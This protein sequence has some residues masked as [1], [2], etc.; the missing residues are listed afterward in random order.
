M[1]NYQIKQFEDKGL[2]HFSYAVLADNQIV[3]IDPARD[4]QP[5]YDFAAAHDA[6]IIG[7]IETHPHADFVS[8]HDEI[9][10]TTGATLYVSEMVGADYRFQAFDEGDEIA[11]GEGIKLKAIHTPGHSPDSI[12][13]VLS[14]NGKNRAVF[15]GDTLFIGDVG[16][17]DLREKAGKLQAK[18]EE[19]A[20][21][22][23]HSTREKLMRLEDDVLVYPAHGSGSLCGKALSDA[24]SSTIGQEKMSNYALQQMTEEEFVK[25]LLEDQ[26]FIPKYFPYNVALNK[27][28]APSYIEGIQ[29]VE[30]LNKNFTPEAGALII[31]GR[32]SGA[33]RSSHLPGAI[34]LMNGEKFETWLGS[35]VSPNESFY[36]V[37]QDQDALELLIEKSAKIGYELLIKGAFVYDAQDGNSVVE[38]DKEA[39][40]KDPGAYTIVDI[41]NESETKKGL[42]FDN[43][44]N[45][46]LPELRERTGEIPADK[47]VVVHCAGGYR[48]AA[49]SSIIREALPKTTVFDMSEA[50]NEFK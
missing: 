3:L 12:S 32:P 15:T 21:S 27:Q 17:P 28:G 5:Y 42:V 23:Y 43:A 7:V 39:F 19:L 30:R 40:K 50:I 33:F 49:G 11:L 14:E 8:S 29:K 4:S 25:I 1:K 9:H 18:R 48:S 46:P 44:I 34:N 26:P 20:R 2:A 13:I 24:N 47:P 22:M 38:F 45:I 41:R 16:R 10:K 36:L 6:K 31:D 37:A 35:I